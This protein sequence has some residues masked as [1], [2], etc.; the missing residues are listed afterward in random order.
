MQ[1]PQEIE[2]GLSPLLTR[3]IN[4]FF[5]LQGLGLTAE[6]LTEIS[7]L[8][9]LFALPK[10]YRLPPRLNPVLANTV[11]EP[12]PLSDNRELVDEVRL[13]IDKYIEITCKE[14]YLRSV[15]FETPI[16]PIEK[17]AKR[18]RIELNH[19]LILNK[20]L[21]AVSM[22]ATKD[23]VNA[24]ADYCKRNNFPLQRVRFNRSS[25]H[26]LY[27]EITFL[28]LAIF[29]GEAETVKDFVNAPTDAWNYIPSTIWHFSS[30]TALHFCALSAPA[31][32]ADDPKAKPF[33]DIANYLTDSTRAN[34]LELNIHEINWIKVQ[35]HHDGGTPLT[36]AAMHGS[37]ALVKFLIERSPHATQPCWLL[38]RIDGKTPFDFATPPVAAFMKSLPGHP[39]GLVQSPLASGAIMPPPAQPTKQTQA[40]AAQR[41]QSAS[42]TALPTPAFASISARQPIV[43]LAKPAAAAQTSSMM[44]TTP[45][46]NLAIP[47][48]FN[49]SLALARQLTTSAQQDPLAKAAAAA[50]TGTAITALQPNLAKSSAL[51]STSAQTSVPLSKPTAVAQASSTVVGA[52]LTPRE[53]TLLTQRYR[54]VSPIV[55]STPTPQSNSAKPAA[56][57]ISVPPSVSSANAV[58]GGTFFQPAAA[59]AATNKRKNAPEKPP[60]PDTDEPTD[61]ST[62]EEASEALTSKSRKGK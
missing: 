51:A 13:F 46:S 50:Q 39:A 37:T 5:G 16:E 18:F 27:R 28:H 42:G 57:S 55:V 17:L 36:G 43:P 30:N 24:I 9:H 54:A 60:S 47:A 35:C 11:N 48:T 22:G 3:L 41:Q 59:V 58:A 14:G 26:D 25:E 62:N 8:Q 34:H 23:L 20:Y 56:A 61:E 7:F 32:P 31:G 40:S 2:S 53:Y 6:V 1:R 29:R 52:Q 44:S 49:T 12:S 19:G 33:I 4:A 10:D 15:T 21:S 38:P 45:Q